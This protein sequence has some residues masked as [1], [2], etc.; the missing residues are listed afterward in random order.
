MMTT[1][2]MIMIKEMI[3]NDMN[4]YLEWIKSGNCSTIAKPEEIKELE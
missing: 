1:M 2:V 3:D 4:D